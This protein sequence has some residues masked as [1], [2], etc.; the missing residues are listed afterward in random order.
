MYFNNIVITFVIQHKKINAYAA[1]RAA[2][3]TGDEYEHHTRI[4]SADK[5][6]TGR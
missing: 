2:V 5:L 3:M 4:P 1:H 6:Y